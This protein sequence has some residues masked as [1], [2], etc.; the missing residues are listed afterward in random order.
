[1]KKWFLH[2]SLLGMF[3]FSVTCG[4][5]NKKGSAENEEKQPDTL[6]VATLY[7][8]T[9]Y[10]NYRGQE[11]GFD[12][13]NVKRF[14]ADAGYILDLKVAPNLHS[15]INMVAAGDVEL[16]AYPIPVIE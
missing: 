9:S 6:H 16:A 14:A 8:P 4:T 2:I 12:Y 11:M 7:G 1:M 3:V 15:L 13:E 5:D 10:F